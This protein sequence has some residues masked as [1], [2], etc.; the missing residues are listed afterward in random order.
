MRP[1]AQPMPLLQQLISSPT[2]R[3]GQPNPSVKGTS[4]KRAP[5]RRTSS[6]AELPRSV[7]A[8]FLDP[9]VEVQS[10]QSSLKWSQSPDWLP[11]GGTEAYLGC[12]LP[13]H[14]S[15]D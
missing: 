5:V 14:H 2:S 4:R 13:L 6:I 15:D 12:A 1:C 10:P 7:L 9:R 3:R 8:E 11:V